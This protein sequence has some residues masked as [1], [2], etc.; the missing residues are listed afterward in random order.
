MYAAHKLL[1]IHSPKVF[2]LLVGLEGKVSA[3]FYSSGVCWNSWEISIQKFYIKKER[4]EDKEVGR[5]AGRR[6]GMREG[7]QEGM[8]EGKGGRKQ[9]R[10][11]ER[12]EKK[13]AGGQN[14][15]K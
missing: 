4:K 6:E 12:R 3:E 8:A 11:S 5:Q 2:T 7:K 13:K 10:L 1:G 14:E 15:T 9:G